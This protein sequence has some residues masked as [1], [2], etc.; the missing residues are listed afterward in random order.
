M[1]PGYS[2]YRIPK[3]TDARVA[4]V[5]RGVSS[6]RLFAFVDMLAFPRHYVA[7]R[8]ANDRARDLLLKLLRNFG[9][10]AGPSREL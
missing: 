5:L 10:I 1:L 7:E 9:Y 2:K 3:P 6:E 4:D 8:K